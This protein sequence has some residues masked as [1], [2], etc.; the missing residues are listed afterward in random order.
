MRPL[1]DNRW[2]KKDAWLYGWDE[3]H[4]LS[5]SLGEKL[6]SPPNIRN[7]FFMRSLQR[8]VSQKEFQFE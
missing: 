4:Q 1:E 7:S 5:A 3:G 6:R 2:L 8:R